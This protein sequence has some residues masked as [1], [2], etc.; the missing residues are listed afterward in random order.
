[1]E[2]AETDEDPD[3]EEFLARDLDRS[4]ADLRGGL[5]ASDLPP[6]WEGTIVDGDSE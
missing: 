6:P 2:S 3:F 1:M 5:D 4:V